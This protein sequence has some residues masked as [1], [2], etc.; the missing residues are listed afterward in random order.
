MKEYFERL[1]ETIKGSRILQFILLL[2]FAALILL[3][4]WLTDPSRNIKVKEVNI[5]ID[6]T[7]SNKAIVVENEINNDEDNIKTNNKVN[8]KIDNKNQDIR[9]LLA[10]D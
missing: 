7:D 9:N 6:S 8:E 10:A 2:L 1:L 4:I 5:I 3:I